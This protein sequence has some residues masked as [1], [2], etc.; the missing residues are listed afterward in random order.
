VTDWFWQKV[1]VFIAA[2]FVAV[3]GIMACQGHEVL[4]QYIQRLAVETD[5]ARL[6]LL[7]TQSGLRY[8]VMGDEA[9]AE[10]EA[11]AKS[12]FDKLKRALDTVTS[13]PQPVR[14][15]ALIKA[16][17]AETLAKAR[18]EFQPAMPT[19]LGDVIYGLIGAL[20]GFVI[21]EIVKLPVLLIREPKRRRFRRR[22]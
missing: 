18:A 9:R 11:E 19:T 14:P 7:D 2:I 1:D 16:H 6:H 21:Y 17:D 12:R 5:Q 4:E 22:G 20:V 15:L 8:R 13:A 3:A 10:H